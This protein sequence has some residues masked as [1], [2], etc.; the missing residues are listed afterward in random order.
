MDVCFVYVCVH[1]HVRACVSVHV[2]TCVCEHNLCV[3]AHVQECLCTEYLLDL[4]LRTSMAAHSC[5]KP[6]IQAI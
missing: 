1:M 5:L 4:V 3:G 2:C 6:L